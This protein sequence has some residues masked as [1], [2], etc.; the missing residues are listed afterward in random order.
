MVGADGNGVSRLTG[1]HGIVG[2]KYRF[3][4]FEVRIVIQKRTVEE[5][6]VDGFEPEIAFGC[7]LSTVDRCNGLNVLLLLE[8]QNGLFIELYHTTWSVR[9]S[10]SKVVTAD[11]SLAFML[12]IQ[13]S[14]SREVTGVTAL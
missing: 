3:D 6:G 7:E 12:V 5:V 9:A 8:F 2:N 1:H 14:G 10:S 4:L 13:I 11:S